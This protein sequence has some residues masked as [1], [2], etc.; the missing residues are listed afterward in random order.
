[1]N[2]EQDEEQQNEARG[3]SALYEHMTNEELYQ[4]AAA[5]EDLTTAA[6]NALVVEM[7]SRQLDEADNPYTGKDVVE[8]APLVTI[9]RFDN[10]L[11]AE[12][13][14]SLLRSYDVPS[15]I[16][17]NEALPFGASLPVEGGIRLQV[18]PSKI[19]AAAEI[20]AAPPT[21]ISDEGTAV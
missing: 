18:A 9:R 4:L 2:K 3:L 16:A 13:A 10:A 11:E 20:L 8:F 1:M 15:S 5:P 12:M 14:Q 19:A 21:E 17:G 6:Q 7:L